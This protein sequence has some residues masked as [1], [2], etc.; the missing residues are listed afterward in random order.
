MDNDVSEDIK[1]SSSKKLSKGSFYYVVTAPDGEFNV[2]D[3]I[4]TQKW[5]MGV[6]DDCSFNLKAADMNQNGTI[7]IADLCLIKSRLVSDLTGNTDTMR[8]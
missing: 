6:Y 5:L 2:T 7:D 3:I 4:Q 1:L 8:Y